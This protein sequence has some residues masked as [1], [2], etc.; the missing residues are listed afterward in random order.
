M[1]FRAPFGPTAASGGSSA[2]APQTTKGVWLWY[3][4]SDAT[5]L[6]TDAAMTTNVSADGNVIGGVDEYGS[7]F[8]VTQSTTDN[9]PLYKTGV[10]NNLSVARFDDSNDY[11]VH[12]LLNNNGDLRFTD[13]G[14]I[15]IVCRRPANADYASVISITRPAVTT[16]YLD[17]R[18]YSGNVYL[19]SRYNNG[20]VTCTVVHGVAANTAHC[21]TFASDGTQHLAWV[22]GAS[23]SVSANAGEWLNDGDAPY[24]RIAIGALARTTYS[25]YFDGDIGEIVMVNGYTAAARAAIESYL[26]TK[27]GLS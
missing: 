26:M 19:N 13:S 18:Y 5:K 27:W 9:K 21:I 11:L 12:T 10:V 20:T 17:I 2:T 6:Y 3:D 23:Q 7:A 1:A 14:F 8:D 24:Y 4:F 16:R 25:Q 22:N 15:S